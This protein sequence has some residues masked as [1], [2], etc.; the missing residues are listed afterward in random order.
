MKKT[1]LKL[2]WRGVKST[3]ARFLSIFAIVAIGVGFL[4]GLLATTP[5]MQLTADQYYDDYNLFDIDIKGTLGL[6]AQDMEAIRN[7]DAVKEVMPSCVADL[8]MEGANGSYVTRIYGVPLDAYGSSGFI[9]R[10]KLV[11]GRMPENKNECLIASPNSYANKHVMGEVFRISTD[12]KDYNRLGETYS[13]QT[14]TAVGIVESPYYMSM[15]S[16]PSTVGTGQ[17]GLVMYVFPECYSLDAY[18]D[19]FITLD[20]AQEKQ[21]FS[22]DYET[23]IDSATAELETFGIERS[24]IRYSDIVSEATDKLEDARTEYNSAQDEADTGLAKA[25]K[26]LDDGYNEIKKAKTRLSSGKSALASAEKEISEA[27]KM[28][29]ESIAAKK[30]ALEAMRASIS[31]EQYTYAFAEIEKAEKNG[32]STI[33]EKEESLESARKKIRDSEKQIA[34]NEAKLSEGETDYLAAKKE[35]GDKLAEAKTKIDKAQEDIDTLDVPEWYVSDRR[36]TVSFM[37]YKGNSEKIGAIAKVFPIFFFLV[38]ALVALTTMTRMVEEERPQIG[39]LKALG[40]SNRIIMSYYIGY[41][42]LAS[43]LGSAA[44]VMLGF[45]TLPAI[46]SNA[47]GMMYT[48]PATITKFWWSYTLVIVPIAVACTTIATL[49]ACLG[50][51]KEKPSQ[52]M[53]PRAPKAG[54]RILLERLPF[55]WKHMS[56]TKKV[57][58]RNI[59]RYRK[60]FYMTVFG[61]AGCC[62]LLVTGFGLRDSIRDIVDKQFGEIYQYNL[63]IYLKEDGAAETDKIVSGFLHNTDYV[64]NYAVMHMEKG[65]A[66]ISGKSESVA[67]YVPKVTSELKKQLTLRDRKSGEDIAFN[68]NSVVLTEKLCETLHIKTG[69]TI[70]LRNSDGKS[71]EFTVSG[72][73]ENYI[74]SFAFISTS[75]YEK[76]FMIT[77]EYKLVLIKATDDREAMRNKI[78]QEVLKSDNVMLMQYS[79]TIRDSFENTVGSIDY[80]VIVLILSAGAL[81]IIVL[82]N[83]TNI[84]ICERKKELATIKVL[85]FY[86]KEVAS[87]IYR[88]TSVLCLIGTLAGFGFGTWLHSF[89]VKTAEVDAVMFGRS[90]Y[91]QSYLFAALVTIGFTILVDLVMLLKLKKINMVESMKANE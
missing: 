20:G 2:L 77:P 53:L 41:S 59:L 37:S 91:L 32:L 36:D 75:N 14:L 63:S 85:G 43:L 60:R 21:S 88:E 90:I 81:A 12:N 9:N 51:L 58:A 28:L 23:M 54:K 18:T 89:V 1:Y 29:S 56:F 7:L 30:S 64:E 31:A 25:R 70:T 67:I 61:I 80:I 52:V 46:I 11:S 55:I 35:A 22:D 34:D 33:F 26:E 19:F 68:E 17:V 74:T 39:T 47:Y 76:A 69:D 24:K 44:G 49:S 6:T 4:A 15:E 40:Y 86:E 84:N 50:Q 78:S 57:T 10:F 16:E 72:I 27:K 48:L 83:L 5:D 65:F 82:Y 8:N 71:A 13:F 62:A 38:A 3:S 73:S 66:E 79:Q 42:V 87:Y 45:G